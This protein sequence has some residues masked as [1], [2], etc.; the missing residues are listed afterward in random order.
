MIAIMFDLLPRIAG[1]VR[2]AEQLIPGA[3]QGAKRLK[4]V[5]DLIGDVIQDEL[6]ALKPTIER[7]VARIVAVMNESGELKKPA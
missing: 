5:L 1:F 4:L 2:L 6:P 3:G 7:V